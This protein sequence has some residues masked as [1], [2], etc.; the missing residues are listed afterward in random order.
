MKTCRFGTLSLAF[1]ALL[2]LSTTA[3]AQSGGAIAGVVKDCSG[4]V[5]PGVTVEVGQPRAH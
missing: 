2:M 5:M 4:A 3:R 1:A